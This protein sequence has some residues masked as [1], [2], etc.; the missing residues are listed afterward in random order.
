MRI[1]NDPVPYVFKAF[2]RLYGRKKIIIQYDPRFKK[3]GDKG[4]YGYTVQKHREM[5]VIGLNTSLSI[6]H[7][8]GILIHELAHVVA[9]CDKGHGKEWKAVKAK[10]TDETIKLYGESEAARDE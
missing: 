1:I 10:L 7:L 6:N 5:P 2:A 9:G 8:P 4:G 3:R